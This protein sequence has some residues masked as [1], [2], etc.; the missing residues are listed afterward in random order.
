MVYPRVCGGTIT[1]STLC[2][3][4]R[5][6]SPRVRGNHRLPLEVRI[7]HGSIP[8]CAGEP[9]SHR[10]SRS[11]QQVYPRVCG[12]TTLTSPN[13]QW[14]EGLSPRVRGNLSAVSH[15][16]SSKRS[17]PACAGEPKSTQVPVDSSPGLS[18]RVRG[19]PCEPLTIQLIHGS[20]PACAGEPRRSDICRRQV[21]VYPR[22]CG[23]TPGE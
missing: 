2:V 19:N 21:R 16:N 23:G 11:S 4:L 9:D 6:L 18:P 3:I 20:I 7:S 17:I 12:G 1:S 15:R 5:G 22:V 10:G 8:A 13:L 14:L